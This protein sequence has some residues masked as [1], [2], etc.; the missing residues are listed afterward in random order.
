MKNIMIVICL[1]LLIGCNSTLR[2]N[3]PVVDTIKAS[4]FTLNQEATFRTFSKLKMTEY[5]KSFLREMNFQDFS[6]IKTLFDKD[7][8]NSLFMTKVDG[9]NSLTTDHSK[10]RDRIKILFKH[11]TIAYKTKDD[12]PQGLYT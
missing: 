2:S 1:I 10:Y 5:D 9:G 3:G 12:P 7:V 6:E 8:L 4:D 11:A